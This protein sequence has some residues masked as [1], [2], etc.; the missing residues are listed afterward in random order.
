MAQI[1]WEIP[2]KTVSEGNCF[3]HYFTKNKRHK[4]QQQVITLLFNA[5]KTKIELPCCV[6]MIRLGPRYLD[7]E[8]NLPM[9]FKWI[10]D[11]IGACIFPDKVVTYV[12]KK[13]HIRQNKG[14][15]DSDKRITWQYDQE[16]SKLK[17]IR[18]EI[19]F[20]QPKA[21]LSSTT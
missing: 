5:E 2:L 14:H 16:K 6:K 12:T 1:I 3:E 17:G 9:A 8:E 21:S 4:Q 10:K 20:D 19:S 15:A 13:G 11:Q 18:I 7:A